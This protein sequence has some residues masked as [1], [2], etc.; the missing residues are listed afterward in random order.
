MLVRAIRIAN[1]IP[2]SSPLR[3][4]ANLAIAQW[5]NRILNIAQERGQSDIAGAIEIAKLVP[6][7]TE[8]YPGAQDQIATWERFLNPPKPSP[9][10]EAEA[11]STGADF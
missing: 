4:D 2:N 5:S 1:G 7:G 8:A 10:P 6:L 9:E 11:N 3:C